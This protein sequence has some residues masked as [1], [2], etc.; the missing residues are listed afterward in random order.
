MIVSGHW[1]DL[2]L[3][4]N[5]RDDLESLHAAASYDLRVPAARREEVSRL[6]MLINSQ[7]FHGHF[8]HWEQEGSIHYR[9]SLLLAGGAVATDAQC[10]ALL[11]MSTELCELYYPAIQYVCWAGRTARDALDCIMFETAGEA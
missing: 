1:C 10:D 11:R 5:W 6:L 2:Y 7:L 9:N 4:L 3:S 8:D